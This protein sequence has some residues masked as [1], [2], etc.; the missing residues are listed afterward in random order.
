[1]QFGVGVNGQDDLNDLLG[2]TS[3]GIEDEA[4]EFGVFQGSCL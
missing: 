3:D 4:F 2:V 1:L